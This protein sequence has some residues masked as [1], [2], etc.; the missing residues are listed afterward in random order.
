MNFGYLYLTQSQYD[1]LRAIIKIE[2]ILLLIILL[3]AIFIFIFAWIKEKENFKGKWP[4][5]AL[6]GILICTFSGYLMDYIEGH[7]FKR[8]LDPDILNY[9]LGKEY[10]YFIDRF[11]ACTLFFV[12][13]INT[14]FIIWF[15]FLLKNS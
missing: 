10:I 8:R 1:N 15:L 4:I 3:L 12:L 7:I 2:K 14:I 13:I 11:L 6:Q 5:E 9:L